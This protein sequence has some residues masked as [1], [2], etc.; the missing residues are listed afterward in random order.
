MMNS[1]NAQLLVTTDD[2]QYQLFLDSYSLDQLKAAFNIS[3]EPLRKRFNPKK[4][5]MFNTQTKE[6]LFSV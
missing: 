5:E 2:N 4:I 3:I 1:L 6:L